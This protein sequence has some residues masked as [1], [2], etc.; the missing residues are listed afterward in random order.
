MIETGC[1]DA[2]RTP[3][4]GAGIVTGTDSDRTGT[5]REI[6][7]PRESLPDTVIRGSE[8]RYRL[9]FAGRDRRGQQENRQDAC[10]SSA[11]EKSPRCPCRASA[12]GAR[13][14]HDRRGTASRSP[15]VPMPRGTLRRRLPFWVVDRPLRPPSTHTIMARSW[16]TK[17][18]I[19]FRF[20]CRTHRLAGS[21]A[22]LSSCTVWKRSRGTWRVGSFAERSRSRFRTI[23]V[24]CWQLI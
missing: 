1:G 23:G 6:H 20:P 13:A 24:A 14:A 2:E 3:A 10:C 7:D 16:A 5:I 11:H 4:Q 8:K 15:A 12:A 21:L 9:C 18:V 19:P 17:Y 22:T